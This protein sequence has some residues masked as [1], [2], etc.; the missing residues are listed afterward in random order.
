MDG[1]TYLWTE[2]IEHELTDNVEALNSEEVREEWIS[3]P[4]NKFF[5][6]MCEQ[7]K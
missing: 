4:L 2:K 7:F 5:W 1:D 6:L 3:G